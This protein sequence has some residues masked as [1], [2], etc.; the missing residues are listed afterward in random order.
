MKKTML[1]ALTAGILSA[2]GVMEAAVHVQPQ[3]RPQPR[4]SQ[5]RQTHNASPGNRMGQARNY[6]SRPGGMHINPDYF[7]THFG[8]DHRF[9]FADCG[10]RVLGGELYFSFNG[11]WF[12]VMGP[13]PGNWGFQTDYLYIGIGDDG[14]YYLYDAQFPDVSVQLTFVQS[15]GDDQAGDDQDQGDDDQ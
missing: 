12:G 3:P 4:Q 1:V 13:M 10:P 5:P 14:N 11:G 8:H 2:A 6:N 7:A 9:R 15:P